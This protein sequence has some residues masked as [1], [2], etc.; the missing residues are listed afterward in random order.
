[1]GGNNAR[2][3]TRLVTIQNISC[4]TNRIVALSCIVMS[5]TTVVFVNRRDLV[6]VR[7]E[8]VVTHFTIL[9]RCVRS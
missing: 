9:V 7:N 4:Y 5:Y 1:M 8:N 3:V 2:G 6:A